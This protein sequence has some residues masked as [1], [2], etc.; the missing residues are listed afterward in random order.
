M[1]CCC[2]RIR[3]FAAY[4][5]VI[6]TD[7]IGIMRDMKMITIA[8]NVLVYAAAKRAPNTELKD[9]CLMKQNFVKKTRDKNQKCHST[10]LQQY[11]ITFVCM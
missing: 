11:Y 10:Y 4:S 1:A 3:Y 7:Q 9:I 8:S 2:K 6:G 5:G